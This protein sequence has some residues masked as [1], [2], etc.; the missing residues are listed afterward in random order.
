MRKATTIV[1]T[2]EHVSKTGKK[3]KFPCIRHRYR[4][5]TGFRDNR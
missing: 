5:I 3:Q 4:V 1:P 2:A